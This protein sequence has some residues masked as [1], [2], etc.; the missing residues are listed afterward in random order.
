[1]QPTRLTAVLAALALTAGLAGSL[2]TTA[3]ADDRSTDSET[4]GLRHGALEAELTPAQGKALVRKAEDRTADTARALGLGTKEGLVVKNVVKDNDGTLH[5]RY[6]RTY[7]GLPVLGGD[8]VVH[9]APASKASGT[10]ATTFNTKHHIRVTSTTATLTK[11]QAE[12]KAL[13]TARALD[14]RQPAAES[15]RK[16]LWAGS[17][18]PRLAWETVI[19]GL[20]DDGTPS[21][22]HVISDAD[23]GKE[24]TRYQDIKTGT[25]NTQYSGSVTLDTTRSGSTYQLTD[26]TRGSHKTYSLNNATSGTGT[27]MT[28]ADDVWG[29]GSGSQTQTAGADAAYGAQKTWDFFKNTLG[30]SGIRNDGVAAYSRVHYGSAYANAYWDDSCFCMTYGDG[31]GN[32]HA[33]TSLDIAAHEMG[34]GVTSNTAG[35]TYSGESGGLNEATSDIF[36]AGVEFYADNSTDVGDYLVG[37]KVDINSN[38]SPLRYMD[39][40]SKDG[41]SVDSWYSGLGNLDVHYSSGPANHMFYLLSEGSGSKTINGVTYNSPTAD[42]VAVTGIGRDA[43]L[44][45]WYKALTTYMTSSTNYA[46]ARTA[47]LNAA[48]ALYGTNSAQYAAVGN[49]FAGINVGSHITP[50]TSGVTV[51]NPGSQAS[52]VGTPVSLQVQ[53]SSTNSGSLTYSAS[54]LPAGLSINASTGIISGTPTTAKAYTTTVTVTDSTG[55]TGTAAFTWTISTGGGG[56]CTSAQ[57]LTNPGFESGNTGWTNSDV[58][59]NDVREPAHGGSYTAWL[60]G[61]GSAHT[62]TLSQTVTIPAACKATLTFYLHID[63]AEIYAGVY[64]KLT[65]TAGSKTLA[66]YSNADAA[67]GY[68]KKSLDLS[69]LAGQ[70]VTLK[71]T[72]V[73]D[74]YLA[75]NFVV[76]DTALT[77]G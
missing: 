53:A 22:L 70:T 9:T 32:T 28:D 58:I 18:T 75:T 68:A 54:G 24:I 38:G 12:A 46:G 56:S 61:W 36:G 41:N 48:S 7:A 59:N 33:L 40:P 29:T 27:L 39:K 44:K 69:S 25:G 26:T 13:K 14:A 45:I 60:N 1:M 6:E 74:A 3:T 76:D 8:L 62:D 77:T 30:R 15:A 52:A 64:D 5:T 67:N 4:R 57:L 19:G 47:A 17:G 65:L 35:L 11:A 37:E 72:G 31:S 34:H 42:S 10:V 20:Q 66:T 43:A 21:R 23:T 73:E 71:F 63:T 55:T 50:P 49:A 51:T 2:A 16:V